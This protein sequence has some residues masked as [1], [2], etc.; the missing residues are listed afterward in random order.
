MTRPQL[1]R[2]AAGAQPPPAALQANY[3]ANCFAWGRRY[4]STGI[5]WA[6][7]GN[8]P[9]YWQG[10]SGP[11]GG[12]CNTPGAPCYTVTSTNA[13]RYS[14]PGPIIARIMALKPG[15][16]FTLQAFILVTGTN[17]AYSQNGTRWDCTSTNPDLHWTNDNERYC[18]ND[19]QQIVAAIATLPHVIV[20]DPLSVG[21]AFGRPVSYASS[22]RKAY[23]R[24]PVA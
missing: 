13:D 22:D 11:S 9:P 23:S 24:S 21:V 1:S 16:W 6:A 10:T 18:Y 8:T 15:Q 7:A 2:G 3:S 14:P 20:T 19:W 12:A 17:P 5:T 4:N